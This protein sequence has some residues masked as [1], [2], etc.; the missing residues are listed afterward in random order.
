MPSR[1][2]FIEKGGKTSTFP[3]TETEFLVEITYTNQKLLCDL[4]MLI[5]G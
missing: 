1:L 4:P 2:L 5:A 3:I